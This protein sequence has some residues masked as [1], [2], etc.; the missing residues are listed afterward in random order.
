MR[1]FTTVAGLHGLTRSMPAKPHAK[2][3]A[4]IDRGKGYAHP[5][6]FADSIQT[7]RESALAKPNYQ[8]DK[9]QRDLAKKKKQD[10]KRQRKQTKPDDA[11]DAPSNPDAT[12]S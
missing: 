2:L 4:R 12:P 6:R 3:V 11:T 1:S 8:F 10:E 7:P 5:G 9:R